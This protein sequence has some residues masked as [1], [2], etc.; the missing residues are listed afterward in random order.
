VAV[1]CEEEVEKKMTW[2]VRDRTRKSSFRSDG[3][4]RGWWW[5]LLAAG[6]AVEIYNLYDI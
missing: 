2:F 6:M 5:V 1:F 3:N 4:Y